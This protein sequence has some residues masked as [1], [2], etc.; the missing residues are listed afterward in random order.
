MPLYVS[1]VR[2][3]VKASFYAKF[4]SGGVGETIYMVTSSEPVHATTPLLNTSL[5]VVND[6]S[7]TVV[8]NFERDTSTCQTQKVEKTAREVILDVSMSK[9]D[10]LAFRGLLIIK[11]VKNQECKDSST[12]TVRLVASEQR[13]Y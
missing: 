6:E 2:G 9:L 12:V 8:D 3:L 1:H 4:D 13:R 5:E 11:L 7:P 10:R